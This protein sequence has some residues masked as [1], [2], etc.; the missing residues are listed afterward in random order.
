[1]ILEVAILNVKAGHESA[2]EHAFHE[3]K[4]IIAAM[5]GFLSLERQ[6]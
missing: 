4:S 6:H 2:F 5:P 3:A 1:M